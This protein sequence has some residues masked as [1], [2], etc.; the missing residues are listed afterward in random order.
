MKKALIKE[1][2]KL[3]HYLNGEK[4][5]GKDKYM[6]GDCSRLSGDCTEL[7]GEC[8]GLIGNCS[9]LR[10]DCTSL[11]GDCSGLIGDCSGLRGD[12]D[13]CDITADDREKGVNI[14]DLIKEEE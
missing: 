2:F 14:I 9:G 11:R 10:G 13:Y 4:I 3:Y 6:T 8:S 1:G 5:E 12:L 7:S